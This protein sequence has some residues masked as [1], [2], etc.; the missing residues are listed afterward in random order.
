MLLS[1]F[2]VEFD[3][4]CAFFFWDTLYQESLAQ[5]KCLNGRL[6]V[7]DLVNPPTSHPVR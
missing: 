5:G 7:L 1:Q 6:L 4:Y 2:F 3:F